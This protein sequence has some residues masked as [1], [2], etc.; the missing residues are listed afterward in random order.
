MN[1]HGYTFSFLLLCFF[2]SLFTQAQEVPSFSQDKVIYRVLAVKNE[3]S[4]IKSISNTASLNKGTTIYFP[5]AFTPDQDGIN[6]TFGAVGNNIE[7]YELKIYNKWG[8]LIFTSE[9]IDHKWDGLHKGKL[10]PQG[11]YVYTM[12]ARNLFTKDLISKTGTVTLIQ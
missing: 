4:E 8:E 6:D 2:A 12:T 10:V 9:S 11:A 5:N 3:N 7:K 1:S